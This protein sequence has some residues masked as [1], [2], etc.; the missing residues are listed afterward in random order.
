MNNRMMLPIGM[1]SFEKI[2]SDNYYYVDKT[3]LI[4]EILKDPAEVHLFTRPRR[5]GKS[6]NMSMLRCYL[7]IGMDP[8]LF[9]GLRIAQRKDLCDAYMGKYPVI[10][11]SLKNVDARTYES[12][13]YSMVELIVNEVRRHRFLYDSDQLSQ[14]EKAQFQ[15]LLAFENGKF[16]MT[17]EALRSSLGVLSQFLYSHYGKKTVIL[18]DEYDVPLAKAFQNGYYEEMVSLIRAFMGQALKTNPFLE[19][20]VLTGCLRVSKESIFTGL[21]NF[22]PHSISDL[23]FE[24]YYGFTDDEVQE[25]L[26]YYHLENNAQIVR[27]W[28]DGY[29]FGRVSVYCP[30][31]VINYVYDHKDHPDTRPQN[32][33]INTSGNGLVR[34]FVDKANKTTR[35][36]IERLVSGGTVDKEIRQ[37]L[38]YN[39]IDNSIDNLWSVL[40]TTG[41]LT[42]DGADENG[43]LHLRIPNRE[44]RDVY[45]TQIQDWF[46]ETVVER[47]QPMRVLRGAILDGDA[48]TIERELTAVLGRSISILDT[49]ARDEEKEIFYHGLLVGLLRSEDEWLVRS[50]VES[51]DG[52][53]DILIEPE[54]PDTGIIMELKY[55]RTV[56]AMEDACQAALA[57][58]RDKR[59]NACLL[60]DG[61]VHVLSYGIAFY[62]KR[63]KVMVEMQ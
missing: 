17:E 37:D 6:L 53:C 57:Q 60:E 16:A 55:A 12:A 52:F 61:R 27:D 15:S 39:E 31:D 54:D 25:M 44:V 42:A 62:K 19:M 33:W 23:Q 51:G 20:A 40:Y 48:Q 11:I 38:T 7:E 5:F 22:K 3:E 1:D 36:E 46:K 30:W 26:R 43:V 50:N 24:E 34:R 35:E 14:D 2:R 47:E 45:R 10:A 4:A 59:Y 21:N 32:Y 49:K 29:R 9:D 13:R 18:I 28:Y 41:Y 56:T 58:I 63:C 8:G